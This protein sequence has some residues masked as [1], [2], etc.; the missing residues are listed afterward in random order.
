MK[1]EEVLKCNQA[2]KSI[3]DNSKDV[4]AL[5]KFKLLG[6]CKQF[7]PI[8]ENFEEVKE[9]AIQRYGSK[10][11]NGRFG[12][13]YPDRKQYS[14]ADFKAAVEEYDDAMHKFNNDIRSLLNTDVDINICKFKY[15]DVMN[16]DIPSDC[17]IVLYDFI[18]E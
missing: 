2:I 18:E 11:S 9:E 6:I 17:L 10:D 12:I 13:F 4:S 16:A 5:V 8:V 15:A 14:D 7:E 1:V 3:I